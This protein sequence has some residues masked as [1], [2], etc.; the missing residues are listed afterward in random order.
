V[1]KLI[2][3][4]SVY[5]CDECVDLCADIM[6]DGVLWAIVRRLR[7]TDESGSSYQAA[8]EDVRTWSTEDVASYVKEG[9][10]VLS[11]R[12]RNIQFIERRLALREG[13]VPQEDATA[14]EFFARVTIKTKEDLVALRK[15]IE[16]E[17]MRYEDALRI[18]TTV[19]AER[20]QERGG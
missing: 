15:T 1:R 6:R 16:R 17:T 9:K 14:T 18:G 19:L 10:A 13:E 11:D 20:G 2:A 4:P 5:V 12:R 3:G 8:L 7:S